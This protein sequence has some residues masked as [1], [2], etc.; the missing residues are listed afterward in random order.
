MEPLDD[1]IKYLGIVRYML[2]FYGTKWIHGQKKNLPPLLSFS[3][4]LVCILP[5]CRLRDWCSN[6]RKASGHVLCRLTY[7]RHSAFLIPYFTFRILQ[8]R[9]LPIACRPLITVLSPQLCLHLSPEVFFADRFIRL[10]YL[11]IQLVRVANYGQWCRWW[12][13]SDPGIRSIRPGSIRPH[14]RPKCGRSS[15]GSGTFRPLVMGR[16][17][18]TP[19][20]LLGCP[21]HCTARTT[22]KYMPGF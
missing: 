18:P 1:T 19:N 2:S 21:K 15:T 3:G 12:L 7:Q 9:I 20:I 11:L 10:F 5:H 13:Q 17:A 6:L 4:L 14:V 16:S 8:F 22:P